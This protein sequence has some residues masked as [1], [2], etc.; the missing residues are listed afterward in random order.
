MAFGSPRASGANEKERLAE[1][2]AAGRFLYAH[3]DV[4]ADVI[5]L[6]IEAHA[7]EVA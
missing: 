5:D 2:H 7:V 1:I 3:Q 4:G 6:L